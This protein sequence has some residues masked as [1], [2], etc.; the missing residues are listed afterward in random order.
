MN[1]TK[2]PN[3]YVMADDWAVQSVF[4]NLLSNA[5]RYTPAGGS[6][7]LRTYDDGPG[8]AVEVA[9]TG[10]GVTEEDQPRLFERF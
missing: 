1:P 8:V 5:V 4:G 7:T 9:D 10:I 6:I 3:P 2:R